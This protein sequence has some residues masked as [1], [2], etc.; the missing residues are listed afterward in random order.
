LLVQWWAIQNSVFS[1]FFL[2]AITFFC[3]KAR[4]LFSDCIVNLGRIYVGSNKASVLQVSFLF[5]FSPLW[6]GIG[7]ADWELE[8]GWVLRPPP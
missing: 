4:T 1:V 2:L 3:A 8:W 7:G 6:I 5:S